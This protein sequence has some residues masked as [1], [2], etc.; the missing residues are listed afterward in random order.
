M[1]WNHLHAF[2]ETAQRGSLSGAARTLGLTQP[3][4]SRQIA[5]LEQQLGVTLFERVGR[6]LR[7]TDAGLSLLD[8]ARTMGAAADDLALAATGLGSF[9]RIC[10]A[11][12]CPCRHA[13]ARC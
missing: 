9:W 3:T 5:A 4:L 6:T 7:P 1:D 11:M 8:H 13:T 10:T 12:A 2:L